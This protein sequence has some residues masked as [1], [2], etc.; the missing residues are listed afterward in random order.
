MKKMIA[1]ALSL[2]MMATV[3]TGCATKTETATPATTETAS[4]ATTTE[5][6]PAEETAPAEEAASLSGSVTVGGSTSV[7]SVILA[8]M[9]VFMEANP[10]VTIT[11]DPTGSSTGVKSAADGSYDIGL[12]SRDVKDSE[13]EELKTVGTVFAIDGIAIIV[14]TSNAVSDLTVEDVAA[15]ADGTITN[16]SELGGADAPIVL[17]GREAG[18]GTRDGFESIIGVEECVYEQELASTGGVIGAVQQNPNAIGYAS[19]AAVEDTV[20][21]LTIEGVEATE[22]NIQDGSYKFQRNF[23]FVTVEGKELSA[24]AQAFYDFVLSSEAASLVSGAGAVPVA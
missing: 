8:A 12:A 20:T 4:T 23:N 18:S 9:Q 2:A 21:A 5:A 22:A 17:I 24:A 1:L 13:T 3:F 14:N 10:D 16:W 6:A 15:I 11:Y 7:E 19:V